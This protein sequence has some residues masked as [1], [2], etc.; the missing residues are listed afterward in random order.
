M[1]VFKTP[2]SLGHR[3]TFGLLAGRLVDASSVAR[4]LT[5]GR[6]CPQCQSPLVAKQGEIYIH[7]FAHHNR[8]PCD[9]ALVASI[10]FAAK[11]ELSESTSGV[12]AKREAEY[13]GERI[14]RPRREV[15]WQVEMVANNWSIEH[16]GLEPDLVVANGG[17]RMAILVEI[18]SRIF[19]K[20]LAKHYKQRNLPCMAISL[21]AVLS[22]LIDYK[23]SIELGML[24]RLLL[25]DP[26]CR[27][28]LWHPKIDELHERLMQKT[29]EQHT[30]YQLLG[31]CGASSIHV[32]SSEQSSPL[33][34][35]KI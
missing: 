15:K 2:S 8:Q 7:H 1:N 28:W 32:Y 23:M 34:K 21:N 24:N 20:S 31:N 6:V 11:Q 13:R 10:L 26:S 4:G 3:A 30:Q 29:H 17:Y 5:C 25:Q 12:T 33:A 9:N 18:A 16:D 19:P 27:Y 35:T 22:Q 14:S